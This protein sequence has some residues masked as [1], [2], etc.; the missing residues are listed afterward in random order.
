MQIHIPEWLPGQ[1]GSLADVVKDLSPDV[2]EKV[3]APVSSLA[4]HA[5]HNFV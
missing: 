3:A 5:L 4:D 2:V 1:G